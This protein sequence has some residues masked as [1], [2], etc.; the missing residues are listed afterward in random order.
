[1]QSNRRFG[2]TSKPLKYIKNGRKQIQSEGGQKTKPSLTNKT[3]NKVNLVYY[4]QN[5]KKEDEARM[6]TK[7]EQQKKAKIVQ[8]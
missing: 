7:S 2:K 6:T 1:M 8:Y 3:Y 5:Q 4:N